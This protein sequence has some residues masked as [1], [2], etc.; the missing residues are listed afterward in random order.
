MIQTE[1]AMALAAKEIDGI[2]DL[3]AIEDRCALA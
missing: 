3:D 1:E 2:D